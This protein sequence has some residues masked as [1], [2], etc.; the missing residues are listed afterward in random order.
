MLGIIAQIVTKTN[1]AEG[2]WRTN[3]LE[4]LDQES[5]DSAAYPGWT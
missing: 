3:S 1:P 2:R 5:G 4:T